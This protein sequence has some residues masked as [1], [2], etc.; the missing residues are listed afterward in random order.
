[1]EHGKAEKLR[2]RIVSDAED[3]AGRIIAEAEAEAKGILDEAR[4]EAE[5]ISAESRSRGESEAAEHIRRQVSL[6]ELEARNA[7]LAE[8]GEVISGV[9]D[10]ALEELRRRDR[11]SGYSL[12]RDLLLKAIE[13]GDE[14]IIVA[15]GDREAIGGSFLESLNGELRQAGKRGEVRLA[16]ETRDMKGG[17]VLRKGRAE[18]NSSFE[19]LLAMLRD[20]VETEIAGILFGESGQAQ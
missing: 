3:E 15:P 7:L 16:D 6:R 12:T 4:S 5:R 2:Q 1:M 18:T 19:T 20:E 8:K 10:R 9:F 11:E 17:F 13:T 14:E